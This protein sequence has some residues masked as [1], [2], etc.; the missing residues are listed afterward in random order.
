MLDQIFKINVS[1]MISLWRPALCSQQVQWH[2]IITR[3]CLDQVVSA[4]FSSVYLTPWHFLLIYNSLQPLTLLPCRLNVLNN[5]FSSAYHSCVS[6]SPLRLKHSPDCMWDGS[7]QASECR[8][9]QRSMKGEHRRFDCTRK[10]STA[11]CTTH[12]L[13]LQNTSVPG[14][15]HTHTGTFW[16]L[17]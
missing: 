15:M 4:T 9:Q 6:L 12:P 2:P 1:I 10:L 3:Q 13:V 17:F 14:K 5:S 8:Q 11:H 7:L 16:Q